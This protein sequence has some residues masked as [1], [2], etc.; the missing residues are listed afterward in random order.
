MDNIRHAKPEDA[1]DLARLIDIAGEGLA[2]HLWSQSAAT[3]QTPLEFGIDKAQSNA[4]GFSYRNAWVWE[5]SGNIMGMLLAYPLDDPYVIENIHAFPEVVRP[6]I[7]LEAEAP[8]SFYINGLA[9]FPEYRGQGIGRSLLQLAEHKAP[10]FACSEMSLIVADGNKQAVSLYE[11]C[12]YRE[13]AKRKIVP[14]PGY[15]KG[16]ENWLLMKKFLSN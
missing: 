4:G 2:M 9:T 12:G 8:G 14:F 3:N 1:R 5:D 7:E 6:L 16:S 13:C 11:K 15:P 10:E